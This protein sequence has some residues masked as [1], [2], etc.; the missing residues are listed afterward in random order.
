MLTF[1]NVTSDA[2]R[3]TLSDE[4][5]FEFIIAEPNQWLELLSEPSVDT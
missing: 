3:I 2:I 5:A 1:N 4:R